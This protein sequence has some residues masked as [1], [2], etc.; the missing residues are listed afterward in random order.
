MQFRLGGDFNTVGK[1]YS[2]LG[3]DVYFIK[4]DQ[5]ASVDAKWSSEHFT[6]FLSHEAFHYY[7]QDNWPE[8]SRFSADNLTEDD[9]A[10]LEEEY[11]ILG[12][13]Q[14]QLL[15]D[16]PDK[17]ALKKCA[18]EY[19]DVMNRRMAANEDYVQKEMNAKTMEGT[20]TYAGIQASRRVGYDF[21]VMYFSNRKDVP[22]SE[23][24]PQYRAGNIDKSY[25]AD[26]IPYETGGLLCLLMDELEVPGWQ[27]T[28]NGQTLD[29]PVSLYSILKEWVEG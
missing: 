16:S 24:I 21:G 29:A 9:I 19:V 11:G 20:A 1:T 18:E 17:A 4:Y 27:E 23:I 26:R 8:G 12:D 15:S 2:V 6:T 28:L 25:L 5:A 3:S 10:L 7:M 14:T 13:I 22:F